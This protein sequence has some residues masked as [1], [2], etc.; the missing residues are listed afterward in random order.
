MQVNRENQSQ[1]K[2]GEDKIRQNYEFNGYEVERTGKGHDFKATKRDWLTGKKQKP[3]YIE[4]KTGSSKLSKLQKQKQRQFGKRYVVERLEPTIFG[5]VH[6][7]SILGSKS[8]LK[9]NK[10]RKT[11]SDPFGLNNSTNM[12]G[13]GTPKTKSKTRKSKSKSNDFNS[14]FWGN[15]STT[16][17]KSKRKKDEWSIW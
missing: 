11:K 6:E 14:A 3:I 4:G 7:N 8:Q 1:G 13:F 16:S 5:L 17:K 2:Q 10:T 15:S 12:L 9:P